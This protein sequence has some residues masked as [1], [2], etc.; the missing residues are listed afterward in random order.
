MSED[1]KSFNNSSEDFAAVLINDFKGNN[2]SINSHSKCSAGDREEKY[3][4]KI[5]LSNGDKLFIVSENKNIIDRIL[6][7][8]KIIDTKYT[9]KVLGTIA[10]LYI[11][12]LDR[13]KIENEMNSSFLTE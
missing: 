10:R 3:C 4:Y 8:G 7:D 11:K 1:Y 12:N 2:V 9:G 13:D 6:Y 5:K